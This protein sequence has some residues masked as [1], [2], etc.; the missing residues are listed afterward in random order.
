MH[1]G[2]EKVADLHSPDGLEVAQIAGAQ[3]L[4]GAELLDVF[5]VGPIGGECKGGLIRDNVYGGRVLAVG[6]HQLVGLQ[7]L[8]GKLR[9]GGHHAEDGAQPEPEQGAVPLAE[10][11]EGLVQAGA[12]EV[13]IADDGEGQGAG[14]ER[15]PAAA[16]A[17]QGREDGDG[18]E[19]Q[20]D[21]EGDLDGQSL[22]ISSLTLK[23]IAIAAS[24]TR[25]RDQQTSPSQPLS[26]A[27]RAIPDPGHRLATSSL[28]SEPATSGEPFSV[29]Q[30]VAPVPPS[31]VASSFSGEPP[32]P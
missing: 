4:V 11:V 5:P 2:L 29:P 10:L 17:S 23:S 15:R 16:S 18:E 19:D 32:R 12:Q 26:S 7:E 14:R 13:E 25:H 28:L 8:A 27:S 24:S 21:G 31:A 20:K 3:E 6:E 1:E 9:G 22:S 30:I